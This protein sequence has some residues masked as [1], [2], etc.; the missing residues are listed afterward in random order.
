VSGLSNYPSLKVREKL[1]NSLCYIYS[2]LTRGFSI[3][4][5][6]VISIKSEASKNLMNNY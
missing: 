5:T 2:M 1:F 3:P 4:I 6:V